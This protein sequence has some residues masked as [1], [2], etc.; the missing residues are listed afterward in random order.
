M[1]SEN[2][3]IFLYT[4]YAVMCLYLAVTEVYMKLTEL[5]ADI[6]RRLEK[7]KNVPFVHNGRSLKG[8]D[9]LGFVIMFYKE[10][11]IHLPND[12]GR[13][14]EEDW[15]KTDPLRLIRSIRKLPARSVSYYE[16]QALDLV[17]FAISRDIITHTGIMINSKEFAHMSPKKNFCIDRIDGAWRRRS[18]GAVRLVDI[19]SL[20]L[21]H[22]KA[23]Y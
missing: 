5:E 1:L 4:A 6:R 18:R 14:I 10:Y 19:N 8:L 7:Y 21:S 22:K 17:Y 13:E 20:T 3:N 9:C 15:Y 12:D 2:F 23:H 16:L 11:G